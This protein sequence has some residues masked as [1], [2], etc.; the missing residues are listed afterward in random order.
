MEPALPVPNPSMQELTF[1][2]LQGSVRIQAFE[3][4]EKAGRVDDLCLQS[5]AALLANAQSSSVFSF[6]VSGQVALAEPLNLKFNRLAAQWRHKIRYSSSLRQNIMQP[7]YWDII[8][9]DKAALPFIFAEMK[10]P[11]WADWLFAL[12]VITSD[13]AD[14]P[15][16]AAEAKLNEIREVWL[17]W[18]L[19]K[20][21][22]VA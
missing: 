3:A 1:S 6:V 11:R 8:K 17:K 18:D 22:L 10:G 7:A 19:N 14:A 9:M 2:V 12:R 16:F 21:Y 5:L 4:T 15:Q 13:M 20:N